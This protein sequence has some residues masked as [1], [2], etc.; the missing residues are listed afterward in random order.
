MSKSKTVLLGV[1]VAAAALVPLYGD[2]RSTPVTHP[3]WAR[4]LLRALDMNEAVR[5]SDQASQVFST[6]S[7]RDSLSYRADRYLRA[8][9]VSV[10]EEGGRPRV[11]AEQGVG[12][13]VY[14]VA[15]VRGGDYRIRARIAG[16]PSA[17]PTAEIAA[18]GRAEAI[19]SLTFPSAAVPGWITGGAFYLDPGAYAATILLPPGT[20]LE[21]VEV[22][23]PCL[24]PIEPVGGWRPTAVVRA[25]DIAVTALKAIDRED[26][27]PPAGT[28]IE[29][30]GEDLR[31]DPPVVATNASE[32]G[33][34]E[35]LW[36]KAGSKGL[37]AIVFLNLPEPGLYTL[38]VYG[39]PGAGQSW[40]A[41]SCR[42]A[43]VCPGREPAA[44]GWRVVM[45]NQFNAG[46][47]SFAVTLG[48]GGAIERVR[49]EPKKGAPADYVATLRRLGL[50]MGPDGAVT[51]DKAVDAMKFVRDRRRDS[52][53]TLCGDVE[54]RPEPPAPAP[55][56]A[57]A[58]VTAAPAAP[59]GVPAPPLPPP[60]PPDLGPQEPASPTQPQG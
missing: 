26:E 39:V 14:P 52:I 7:W 21:H 11:V 53:E 36:L 29:V 19:K 46:R 51:P 47:H 38:S 43:V 9:G 49:L 59:P 37:R 12:E 28:P 17:S 48:D 4:M 22:A 31:I 58:P 35:G 54:L 42:K 30:R 20:A 41:D 2:P 1:V 33:G 45:T 40:I 6:L 60:L 27:L 23:P 57:A 50:E 18:L 5:I 55:I 8:D 34:Y 13:V 16:S 24:N 3:L 32:T 25:D 10:S 56:I 44:P 15:L